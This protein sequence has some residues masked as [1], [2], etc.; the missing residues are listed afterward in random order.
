MSG[1]RPLF[2]DVMAAGVPLFFWTTTD[3]DGGG[4][5]GQDEDS[6]VAAAVADGKIAFNCWLKC[7]ALLW[8]QTVNRTKRIKL[9]KRKRRRPFFLLFFFSDPDPSAISGRV[10]IVDP[11]SFSS[12]HSN[13]KRPPPPTIKINGKDSSSSSFLFFRPHYIR[14]RDKAAM[15]GNIIGQRFIYLYFAAAAGE[16]SWRLITSSPYHLNWLGS[17]SRSA[18]VVVV[19]Q[20]VW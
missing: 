5:A 13:A 15:P 9:I 12:F 3:G 17:R 7:I 16:R 6:S 1:R 8:R 2:S 14:R 4:G 11:Y 18:G 20:K 10:L 19:T